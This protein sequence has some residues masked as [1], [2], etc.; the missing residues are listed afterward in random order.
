MR[1]I[2]VLSKS[3]MTVEWD[4]KVAPGA[5]GFAAPAPVQTPGA[6]T[7]PGKV[8]TAQFNS[9]TA[10]FPTFAYLPRGS[11]ADTEVATR[12]PLCPAQW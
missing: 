12:R 1:G 10:R 4:Y 9:I 5:A 8:T 6:T 7:K 3:T 11:S 2:E